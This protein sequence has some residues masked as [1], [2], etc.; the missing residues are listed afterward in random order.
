MKK[1]RKFIVFYG[2]WTMAIVSVLVAFDAQ[3]E[4]KTVPATKTCVKARTC[5]KELP[6]KE[7]QEKI[8]MLHQIEHSS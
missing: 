2:I 5:V 4:T 3:A 6:S 7:D 1:H 8:C